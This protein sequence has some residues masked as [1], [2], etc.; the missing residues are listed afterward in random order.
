MFGVRY[1]RECKHFSIAKFKSKAKRDI[2]TTMGVNGQY[3]AVS[4]NVRI[5][6]PYLYDIYGVGFSYSRFAVICVPNMISF[7]RAHLFIRPT[8]SK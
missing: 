7:L 2:G 1:D 4:H 6:Y 3:K 8:S 5:R